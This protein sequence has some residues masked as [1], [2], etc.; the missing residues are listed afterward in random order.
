MDRDLSFAVFSFN[1]GKERGSD[2]RVKD[3]RN[4]NER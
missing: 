3:S 1:C 2:S 4:P